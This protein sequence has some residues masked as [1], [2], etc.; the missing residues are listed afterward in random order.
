[1]LEQVEYA[2]IR[3]EPKTSL[4]DDPLI[5]M[6]EKIVKA[7]DKRKAV[8]CHAELL[9]KS[10]SSLFFRLQYQRLEYFN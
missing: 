8:I 5:P 4:V 2:R 1:M 9:C 3:A 10:I 7:A 6:I